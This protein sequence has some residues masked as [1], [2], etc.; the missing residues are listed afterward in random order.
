M[1]GSVRPVRRGFSLVELLVALGLCGLVIG[2]AV[3][4]FVYGGHA[5][6]AVT[7]K[8]AGQQAGRKALVAFLSEIQEGMEVVIPRPGTTLSYALV[9]DKVAH[10]RLYYQVKSAPDATTYAL[11]RYVQDPSLAAGVRKE[12]LLDNVRRL[13]FTSRSE[14]ALE[15]NLEVQEDDQVW[16]LITAVRLR[17][18]AS[19]EELW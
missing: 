2:V 6:R 13:S 18:L 14:G 11:W 19:A 17:N 9:R 8:L 12:K 16:S 1:A 7:A 4:L 3:Y 10:L 5:T 15:L